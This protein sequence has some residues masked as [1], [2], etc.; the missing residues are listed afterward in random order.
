MKKVVSISL[1]SS[2]RDHSV[3][4]E[5]MN[6]RFIIE[7]I[8]TDGDIKRAVELLE[9]LDG[10]IDAFGM[11]GIDLYIYVGSKRYSIKD[12][13]ILE[14]AAKITPIVDGSGLK[15]TLERRVI[16]YLDE[17]RIIDFKNSKVLLVSAADRFGMAESFHKAGS[18]VVYG[19]LMFTLGIPYPIKTLKN[20]YRVANMVAPIAVNLPFSLL[21]PTGKKQEMKQETKYEEYYKE[22]HIIAGDYHYIK[23]YMPHSLENKIIITNT[24]TIQDIQCMK[25]RGVAMIITTTPELGGRS[26]GTNVLEAVILLLLGKKVCNVTEKDYYTILNEMNLNPRILDFRKSTRLE[27]GH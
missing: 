9:S 25:Q 15:N 11:G 8:G 6:Q 4:A 3:E 20:F 14:K 1:G 23:K 16:Q 2:S 19:D 7:R 5:F 27:I 26:F 18:D 12:A 10:K 24:T 22:A 21:Y 17:N 13:K